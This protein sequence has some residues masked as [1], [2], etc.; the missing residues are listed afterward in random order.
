LSRPSK[1]II[2]AAG[3]G[4]RLGS[5]TQELPKTLLPLGDLSIF[6]RMVIGLDRI[7]VTDIVV[8]T[9]YAASKLRSH[10]LSFSSRL[11]QDRVKFE[12]IHNDNL[13]VGNVY[14]F[15]LARDKMTEDFILVNSDVVC[16]YGILELLEN[17]AAGETA[18][19]VD[20]FKT[21][22]SEEMKV[23]VNENGAIKDITKNID[24][25]S[26]KG[27]YIG[28]MKVSPIVAQKA[29][30]K[31][32]LLIDGH[33]YPL[34]Y[35]DAFR[36]VAKEEDC[37]FAF[38]TNGLPWTEVDTIDDMNYAKNIILPQIQNLM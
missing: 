4:S 3:L 30:K 36:L 38:S 15:W 20:D 2:F 24:P 1:A 7:G 11:V 27:E 33:K 31:A 9:G 32:K 37:L 29:L 28:I 17:I 14:S 16:H 25:I 13:D 8:V 10:A 22:G 12:F 21:L 34:Y 19:L 26:A 6:D 18:L 23:T 35:E 5:Y